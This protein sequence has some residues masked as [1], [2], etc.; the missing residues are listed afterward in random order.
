MITRILPLLYLF[1][2]PE[3]GNVILRNSMKTKHRSCKWA[4]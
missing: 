4:M 3:S 1:M 2:A